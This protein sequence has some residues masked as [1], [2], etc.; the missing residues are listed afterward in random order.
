ML[1]FHDEIVGEHPE[2]VAPEAA[3]RISEVMVEA[4]RFKCPKMYKACKAEPTLMRKMFK[5]AKCIYDAN[6]RLMV[7]EPKKGN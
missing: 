1:L 7:W 4:L 5:G 3:V 2:S 6:G